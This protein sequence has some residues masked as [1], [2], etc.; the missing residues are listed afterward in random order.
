MAASTTGYSCEPRDPL[1]TL[2]GSFRAASPVPEHKRR[3]IDL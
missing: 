1:A 2:A 3:H